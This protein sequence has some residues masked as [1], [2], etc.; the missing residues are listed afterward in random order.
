MFTRY[1]CISSGTL[2]AL[3]LLMGCATSGAPGLRPYGGAAQHLPG[4]IEAEHYDLGAPGVAYHDVEAENLG[5]DYREA[6]Q[7]DIEARPDA[8]NGHGVGWTR[9]G[10]WIAYSVIVD[11]SGAYTIEFPVASNK[12]G[13]IF[14][15]EMNGKDVTGPIAV[16]DTGGWAH[17][18]MIRAENV[19]LEAGRFLL[20]MVMDAVGESGSIGDI[21]YLRFIK[22]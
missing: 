6:T 10:E 1:R 11:E 8:S 3:T 22:N 17:L 14:H 4:T 18:E 20:K 19:E 15:L 12:R 2:A 7:V 13:G 21:D 5:A 16:P 9:A